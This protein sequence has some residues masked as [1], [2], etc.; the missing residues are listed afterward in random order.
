MLKSKKRLSTMALHHSA[1]LSHFPELSCGNTL[2]KSEYIF[3]AMVKGFLSLTT[4]SICMFVVGTEIKSTY[5]LLF[6]LDL[7]KLLALKL[8]GPL[9]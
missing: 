1:P 9:R 5:D 8:A 7:D 6:K 3:F 4:I 2:K